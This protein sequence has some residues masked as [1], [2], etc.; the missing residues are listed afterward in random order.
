MVFNKQFHM[1]PGV[2]WIADPE[3]INVTIMSVEREDYAY[4]SVNALPTS[5]G[6]DFYYSRPQGRIYFEIARGLNDPIQK[7]NVMYK[8]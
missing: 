1:I 5:G 2:K 8:V 7:V 4:K 3:M 6:L